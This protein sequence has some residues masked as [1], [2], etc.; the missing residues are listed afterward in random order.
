MSG[1]NKMP[2]DAA[3]MAAIL[4]EAGISSYDHRVINQMLEF[5]YKYVTNVLE[6]ARVYCSHAKKKNIDLEDVKLAV[7]MQLDQNYTTPP[8]RDLLADIARS[9]NSTPLPLIKPQ[10]GLRLPPD[11]YCLLATNYKLKQA[12]K[13]TGRQ[14]S[15]GA[16]GS[17]VTVGAA[18]GAK[19]AVVPSKA[20]SAPA[21]AAATQPP[22][23]K[24]K[25]QTSAQTTAGGTP[26]VMPRIQFSTPTSDPT[27]AGLKRKREDE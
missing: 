27:L 6:D 1:M 26:T 2:K 19:V 11:R 15:S 23:P 14:T 4:K 13:T 20:S 7:Q 22:M 5:T 9:R 12:K 17:R 10:C 24:F 18:K 25:V 21:S 3:V 16:A 8:P